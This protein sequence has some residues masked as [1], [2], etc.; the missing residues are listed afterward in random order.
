MYPHN[1]RSGGTTP[2][3]F[4]RSLRL[5]NNFVFLTEITVVPPLTTTHLI[6]R[7]LKLNLR[8]R[9]TRTWTKSKLTYI[10]KQSRWTI[11]CRAEGGG[12]LPTVRHWPGLVRKDAIGLM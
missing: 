10:R 3:T 12:P 7:L 2:P 6:S 8:P 9:A 11:L 4:F 1:A 5:R